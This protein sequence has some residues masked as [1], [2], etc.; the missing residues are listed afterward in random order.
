[1]VTGA[2]YLGV[3]LMENACQ[4]RGST[5]QLFYFCS[6]ACLLGLWLSNDR[7]EATLITESDTTVYCSVYI[8]WRVTLNGL[9]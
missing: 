5:L 6:N 1:M 3:F 7:G 4:V 8:Y 2:C 9:N